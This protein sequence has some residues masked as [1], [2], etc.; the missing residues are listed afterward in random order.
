MPHSPRRWDSPPA[1]QAPACAQSASRAGLAPCAVAVRR[2]QI[3]G[4]FQAFDYVNPDAPK[5]GVARQIAIGTFDNFNL[6]LP[7]SKARSRPPSS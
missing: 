6:S 7:A 1:F 5:G 3:S 4:G 2:R